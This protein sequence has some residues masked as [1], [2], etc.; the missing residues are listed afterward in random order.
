MAEK[1]EDF[2]EVDPQIR[3]QNYCCISF[4]SPEEIIQNKDVF[5]IQKF[6]SN[7]QQRYNHLESLLHKHITDDDRKKHEVTEFHMNNDEL[8]DRYKDFLYVNQEQLESE[9][10]EKNDF[11]TTV[12]GVKVRGIYDTQQEAQSKAK[13]LQN[14]DRN[15]NVYI[16]QVGYWLPWDPNPLKIE[17]QEYA[18]QEL[19]TLV[20]KYKENQDKKDV[21]FQENIDYAK[22]QAEQASKKAL[23][24]EQD[25]TT[26]LNADS[27]TIVTDTSDTTDTSAH[28][29]LNDAD[30]WLQRKEA[31]INNPVPVASEEVNDEQQQHS[32]EIGG[33]GFNDPVPDDDSDFG[34]MV[35]Q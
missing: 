35:R 6:L 7:I 31:T 27:P 32:P 11:K 28:H 30:P 10:Y 34:E 8:Q 1:T 25:S 2:L 19:N 20:K 29:S 4:V 14:T 12:R 23:E 22:D 18:E 3:G 16:G 15:F 24:K 5:L 26:S 9:F 21:H 33:S 13:K 17:N